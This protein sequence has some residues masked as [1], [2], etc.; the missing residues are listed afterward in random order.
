MSFP[1]SGKCDKRAVCH[2][3]KCFPGGIPKMK[4]RLGMV[5]HQYWGLS[6]LKCCKMNNKVFIAKVRSFFEHVSYKT[7][8]KTPKELLARIVIVGETV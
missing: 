8:T 2:H 6:C 4:E 5:Y 7:P 1:D 3:R